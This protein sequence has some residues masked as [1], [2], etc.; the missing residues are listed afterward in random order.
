VFSRA[1]TRICSVAPDRATAPGIG[2]KTFIPI[3]TN[4]GLISTTSQHKVIPRRRA[5]AAQ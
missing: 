1:L 3:G 5:A 4:G 2:T